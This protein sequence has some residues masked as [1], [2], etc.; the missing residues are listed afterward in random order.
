[1]LLILL[2]GDCV[3]LS[4]FG[5]Y[6]LLVLLVISFVFCCFCH[7]E[8]ASIHTSVHLASLVPSFLVHFLRSDVHAS[9]ATTSWFNY[10]YSGFYS[11]LLLSQPQI[12]SW[13]ANKFLSFPLIFLLAFNLLPVFLCVCL[14]VCIQVSDVIVRWVCWTILNW[15]QNAKPI[16]THQSKTSTSSL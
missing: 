9:A 15:W 11:I 4:C 7:F 3:C 1:M 10:Y 2:D 8:I 6:L 13:A 5:F 16:H 12:D 14:F